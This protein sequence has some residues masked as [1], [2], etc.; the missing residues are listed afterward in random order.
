[1]Q[2]AFCST[3]VH[4]RT[5]ARLTCLAGAGYDWTSFGLLLSHYWH[6][7]VGTA[8][9]WFCNNW[10]FYGARPISLPQHILTLAVG[11][12]S[13]CCTPAAGIDLICSALAAGIDLA[14]HVLVPQH[15]IQSLS[16]TG[17]SK[18]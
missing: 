12:H 5:Q 16:D 14:C 8:G 4:P 10:Y 17:C 11:P 6:R 7:L 9:C 13:T 2:L 18:L 1:M 3:I 15:Q